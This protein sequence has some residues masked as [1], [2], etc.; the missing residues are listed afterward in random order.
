MP[1]RQG[2]VQSVGLPYWP[3]LREWNQLIGVRHFCTVGV[4]IASNLDDL[5][6]PKQLAGTEVNSGP[7]TI[8]PQCRGFGMT[9]GLI[10]VW[11]RIGG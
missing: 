4:G 5:P 7:G 2:D 1:E 9:C 6:L 3:F 10:I 11:T 8:P